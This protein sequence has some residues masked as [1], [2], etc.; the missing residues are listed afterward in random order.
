MLTATRGHANGRRLSATGAGQNLNVGETERWLSIAGGGLL[1]LVGLSR[2]SLAGLAAAGVGAGLIYR[3]LSGHC[4]VF[5][6][7]G[8]STAEKHGPNARVYAGH[9]TKVERSVY[10]DRP[11]GELYSFWRDFE[12]LPRIMRH[13]KSVSVRGDR[14]HWTA[15]GPAGVTVEWDAEIINEQPNEMIA[16]GSL[17][18]S[19]VATAGSVHFD[20]APGRGTRL[21]VVLKYDPPAGRAGAAVAGLF[22][23]DADRMIEEDLDRFKQ[24]AESNELSPVGAHVQRFSWPQ[25]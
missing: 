20:E 6:A 15:A 3:G 14:S 25:R 16:W 18:G 13:L 4:Q 5:N 22:G 8:I 21:T 12:N 1:T 11:A 19:E 17:T 23:A 9:G 24:L 7:L 10:I 2:R